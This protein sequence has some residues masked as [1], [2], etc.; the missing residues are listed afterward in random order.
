M[1]VSIIDLNRSSTYRK[2]GIKPI[3]DVLLLENKSTR[4]SK[5][6][7][8]ATQHETSYC[9]HPI[10]TYLPIIHPEEVIYNSYTTTICQC[11]HFLSILELPQN[12]LL[13]VIVYALVDINGQSLKAKQT[14][15]SKNS[16]PV[17]VCC[18]VK[19][20]FFVS[21]PLQCPTNEPLR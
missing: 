13:P 6:H 12:K 5:M 17:T 16:L 7:K 21:S 10:I 2:Q 1:S 15:P 14:Y 3:G 9:S 8:D 11:E 4:W 18:G 20:I 19:Y